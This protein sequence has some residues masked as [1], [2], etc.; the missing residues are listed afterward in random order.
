MKRRNL[1]S[2]LTQFVLVVVCLCFGVVAG[3]TLAQEPAQALL[4]RS[5]AVRNPDFSHSTRVVLSEY[6][7]GREQDSMVLRSHVRPALR[8]GEYQ[9]LVSFLRPSR[10]LGKHMLK[11]GHDLWFY[12]PAS[13]ASIRLSP[14]QRL[15]GQAANADVVSTSL[16]A[17]YAATLD[18]VEDITDG[19]RQRRTATKLSLRA[20][21]PAAGYPRVEVWVD[22]TS[23]AP[24]RARFYSDS[25]AL[26][27]TIFYRKYRA[28]LGA[29]RPTEYVIIDGVDPK[30]VT[31]MQFD[32][33]RVVDIPAQ[34][35]QKDSMHLLKTE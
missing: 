28:E 21:N 23:A 1:L 2:R 14:Q 29:V 30:S 24:I 16:A 10:D 6:K 11:Q 33:F 26:L 3:P 4:A 12:D 25:G 9:T 5:D 15:L 27:K 13:N 34:W 22:T 35:M 19:E 8:K 17:D 18:G 31:L 20:S 32:E 7:A